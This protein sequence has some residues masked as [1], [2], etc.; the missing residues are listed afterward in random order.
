V[1][2]TS[3]ARRRRPRA[4]HFT[5]AKVPTFLHFS[6]FRVFFAQLCLLRFHFKKWIL[7]L[8]GADIIDAN[9]SYVVADV[10]SPR[11]RRHRSWRRRPLIAPD[12]TVKGGSTPRSMALQCA[13]AGAVKN[14]DAVRWPPR[15]G[16]HQPRHRAPCCPRQ[17]Y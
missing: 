7:T 3:A 15:V 5:D 9:F 2:L 13:Y 17:H 8:S 14:H 4:S 11:G 6:P 1:I 10:A 16:Q 12:L